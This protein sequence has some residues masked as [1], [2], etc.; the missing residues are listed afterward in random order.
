MVRFIH[1]HRY[2]IEISDSVE[3][4]LECLSKQDCIGIIEKLENLAQS[5]VSLNIKKLAGFKS[6]YR[7]R[8]RDY[9]IVYE[10]FESKI[11]IRVIL[12]GQR[13]EVYQKLK[14]LFN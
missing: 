2:K 14:R 9:R 6:M 10:V 12:I 1:G 13:K 3:K 11:F 5:S 8:Y 4:Y 7:M